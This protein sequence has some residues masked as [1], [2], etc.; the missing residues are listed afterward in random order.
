MPN[1]F[2]A[3]KREARQGSLSPPP[4][5]RKFEST[6]TSKVFLLKKKPPHL[7]WGSEEVFGLIGWSYRKSG[8]Q[9]LHARVPERAGQG[10]VAG[11]GE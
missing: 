10:D 7:A 8:R 11:C 5:K 1:A 9:F 6:T 2:G 4:T 3:Q